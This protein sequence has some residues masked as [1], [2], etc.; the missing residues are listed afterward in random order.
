ML[1][2]ASVFAGSLLVA[3]FLSLGHGSHADAAVKGSRDDDRLTFAYAQVRT[4]MPVS[5]LRALGLQTAQAERLSIK[6]LIE[7]FIPK[8]EIAFTA[9]NP[10]VENCYLRADCTAYIF[11]DYI[12]QAVFLV[13]AGRVTWKTISTPMLAKVDLK[14]AIAKNEPV[15]RCPEC[16]SLKKVIS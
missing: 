14:G 8:G 6:D 3:S 16:M 11:D 5:E 15:W 13:Q 4:G 9:L 1:R 10:A 12:A 2:L 7:R